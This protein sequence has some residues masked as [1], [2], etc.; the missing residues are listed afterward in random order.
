M[1]L[2]KIDIL[3]FILF[4]HDLYMPLGILAIRPYSRTLQQ[5]I[6]CPAPTSVSSLLST[7][8]SC[9]LPWFSALLYSRCSLLVLC[10]VVLRGV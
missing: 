9:F 6:Q 4:S 8:P 3:L 2:H 1:T 5:D 7:Y 10:L